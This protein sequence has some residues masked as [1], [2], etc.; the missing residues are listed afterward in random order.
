MQPALSVGMKRTGKSMTYIRN[1][2]V[3]QFFL[4]VLTSASALTSANAQ[5]LLHPN[6][7][8]LP[9]GHWGA[10]TYYDNTYTGLGNRNERGAPLS[11]GIGDLTNGIIGT[12]WAWGSQTDANPWVGWDS[13]SPTIEY[14]FPSEVGIET[15]RLHTLTNRQARIH[16]WDA[17]EVSIDGGAPVRFTFADAAYADQ[18]L[19]WLDV[20]IHRNATT[21]EMTLIPLAG[22]WGFLSETEFVPVPE[23]SS[24]ALAAM[25]GAAFIPRARR[26]RRR[27]VS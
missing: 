23:P 3:I 13:F 10:Y 9:N 19:H 25:L 17:V 1:W 18:A 27:N 26:W 2:P 7:Y 15:I 14:T 11:G 5:D 20:P 8:D 6:R 22:K 24:L 4:G 21:V 16:I 12:Q